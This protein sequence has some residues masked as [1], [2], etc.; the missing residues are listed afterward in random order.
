MR[1]CATCLGL[2]Q[3]AY[4]ALARGK[5]LEWRCEGCKKGSHPKHPSH[6]AGIADRIEEVLVVI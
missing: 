2:H 1:K 6:E 3:V 4:A 5:E